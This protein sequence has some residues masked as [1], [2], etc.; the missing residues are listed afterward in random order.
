MKNCILLR[1]QIYIPL[2]IHKANVNRHIYMYAC[3]HVYMYAC[4]R[5]CS[6]ASVVSNSLRP[7]GQ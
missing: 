5:V 6:V 1:F 2:F 3:V 4:V 7:Y